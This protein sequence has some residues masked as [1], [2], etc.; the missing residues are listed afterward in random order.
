MFHVDI[1]SDLVKE[2]ERCT[3][4]VQAKAVGVEWCAAQIADLYANGIP[5]VHIYSLNATASVEKILK[6]VL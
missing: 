3:D 2:I 1:P 5:S 4:D 6:K